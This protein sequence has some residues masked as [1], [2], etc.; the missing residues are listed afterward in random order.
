M[1]ALQVRPRAEQI[2]KVWAVEAMGAV[3]LLALVVVV[4]VKVV[5]V[6]QVPL[7]LVWHLG[8]LLPVPVGPSDFAQ[9]PTPA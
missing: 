8:E 5:V 6:V 1:T 3:A 7:V 2:L 4:A 9:G